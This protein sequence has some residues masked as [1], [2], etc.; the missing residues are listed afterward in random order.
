MELRAGPKNFG[1]CRGLYFRPRDQIRSQSDQTYDADRR[2]AD[3]IP[4]SNDSSVHAARPRAA[5]AAAVFQ[6]RELMTT[7]VAHP[8]GRTRNETLHN[9]PPV[10]TRLLTTLAQCSQNSYTIIQGFDARLANRPF[11]VFDF[12]ALWRS[13]LSARVPDSQKLKMVGQPAW[14]RIP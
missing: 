1:P 10:K 4:R 7:A 14:R 5:A 12:R 3:L 2:I 6:R 13:R 11:L 8:S 9:P